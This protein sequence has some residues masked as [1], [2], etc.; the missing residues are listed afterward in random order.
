MDGAA[1]SHTQTWM[2]LQIHTHTQKAHGAAGG[3]PRSV[4]G[5]YGLV[6][7]SRA[8]TN[9]AMVAP[10]QGACTYP[11][12]DLNAWH[13]SCQTGRSQRRIR[14]ACVRGRRQTTGRCRCAV[15]AVCDADSADP[16][17]SP[18][19]QH[20]VFAAAFSL[21]FL[22]PNEIDVRLASVREQT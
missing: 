8:E 20:R 21:S 22:L 18:S 15:P 5:F 2:E 17:R 9:A 13:G 19:S 14:S 10:R 6:V 16:S 1:D 3:A 11:G 12:R 7:R 4:R